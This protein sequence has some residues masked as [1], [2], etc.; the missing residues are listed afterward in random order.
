[1]LFLNGPALTTTLSPGFNSSFFNKTIFV[2]VSA[3]NV[4]DFLIDR[5][6][7]LAETYHVMDSAREPDLR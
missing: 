4:D 7:T 1:M 6:G 2:D 5:S 3:N